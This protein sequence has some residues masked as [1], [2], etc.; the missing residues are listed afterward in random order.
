MSPSLPA[1]RLLC[2]PAAP[3]PAVA[4]LEA[5]V[6]RLDDGG[7]CVAY[8]LSGEVERLRLPQRAAGFADGLWQH[9]C[10]ELFLAEPGNPAYREFNFSPSGQW[11]AYAFGDYRQPDPDFRHAAAP[12]SVP[13][14]APAISMRH[15]PR[16]L[17]LEARVPAALLPPLGTALEL[18]LSAVVEGEDGSIAWWALAHPGPRP[19]FHR[20]DA[21]ILRLPAPPGSP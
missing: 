7:L 20:R 1:S 9:T 18:G 10:F 14:P 19:D 8:E 16:R 3:C 12:A 13:V 11:A 15:A 2:H 17:E 21:F 6:S 5:R 4:G